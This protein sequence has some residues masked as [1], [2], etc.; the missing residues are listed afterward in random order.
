MLEKAQTIAEE[1]MASLIASATGRMNSQLWNE[2]GRLEALREVNDHVRP[3]EMT[4][5]R[6]H[7]EALQSALCSARVRLDALRLVMCLP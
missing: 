6:E 7:Q 3:D 2:I 1:R 4:A 5:L